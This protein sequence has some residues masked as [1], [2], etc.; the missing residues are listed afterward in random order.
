MHIESIADHP[1]LID[2]IAR[3]H[4][5]EWGHADPEGSVESWAEGLRERTNR[6]AVPTTY[7]ALE[8]EELLGSATLVDND[9]TTRRDLW[10]WVAGVFVKPEC[11]GQGVGSALMLHLVREAAQMGIRK[12]YLHTAK[13]RAFYETLGWRFLDME[14]YE[15]Q[16]VS[17][18]EID[19]GV[20]GD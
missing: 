14:Y 1:H 7:V 17:I 9:M 19:T 16:R 3:W 18:M 11:R 5:D 4:W 12:L 6:N 15:G 8:G 20:P 10:P 2:T 13:A